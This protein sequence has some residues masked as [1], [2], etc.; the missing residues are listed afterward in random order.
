MSPSRTARDYTLFDG[1]SNRQ[2]NR[3]LD[4]ELGNNGGGVV[5][6]NA[7]RIVYDRSYYSSDVLVVPII[8]LNRNLLINDFKLINC[9]LSILEKL[10]YNFQVNFITIHECVHHD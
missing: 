8:F 1:S 4:D 2:T 9:F 5:G 7:P 3:N 10:W 6:A